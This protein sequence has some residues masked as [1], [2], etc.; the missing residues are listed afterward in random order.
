MK[1]DHRDKLPLIGVKELTWA[2]ALRLLAKPLELAQEPREPAV[3]HPP[4][5]VWNGLRGRADGENPVI[6]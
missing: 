3:T 4:P 6:Y 1:K 2:Q 5:M